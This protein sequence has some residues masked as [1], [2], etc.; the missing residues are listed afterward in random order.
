MCATKMIAAQHD[1][2]IFPFL[3][4]IIVTRK[5]LFKSK[6][7]F[8]MSVNEAFEYAV[9]VVKRD[10]EKIPDGESLLQKIVL[11][12]EKHKTNPPVAGTF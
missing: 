9:N 8:D 3:I 11:S 4:N 2:S 10:Y 12:F 5:E 1:S 6:T 7:V